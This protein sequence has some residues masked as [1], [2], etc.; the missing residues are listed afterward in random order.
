VKTFEE[1]GFIEA[2][3]YITENV[4]AGFEMTQKAGKQD[5]DH[6]AELREMVKERKK[7]ESVEEVLTVF[8]HRHG[9][10]MAQCN[11]YYEQLKKEGVVDKK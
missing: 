6:I 1:Q 10:D 8:C 11:K 5:K 7:T 9:V 3:S 4:M 2:R